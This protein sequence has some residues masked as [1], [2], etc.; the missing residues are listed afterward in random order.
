MT[1]KISKW[2]FTLKI[3]FNLC[4]PPQKKLITTCPIIIVTFAYKIHTVTVPNIMGQMYFLKQYIP[5][6]PVSI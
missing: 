4:T 2:K 6:I 1:L 5:T 3:E